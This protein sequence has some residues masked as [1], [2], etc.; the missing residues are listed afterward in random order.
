MSHHLRFTSIVCTPKVWLKAQLKVSLSLLQLQKYRFLHYCF[1]LILLS[2]SLVCLPLPLI[3]IFVQL[4]FTG[5]RQT[6]YQIENRFIG[7]KYNS[8]FLS[9]RQKQS[10]WLFSYGKNCKRPV[11]GFIFKLKIFSRSAKFLSEF[12]WVSVLMC[13]SVLGMC[14]FHHQIYESDTN[15]EVPTDTL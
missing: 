6:P 3:A 4:L 15:R 11:L 2:F 5:F 9:D 1:F 12:S 7:P 8:M 13:L 14:L 10:K